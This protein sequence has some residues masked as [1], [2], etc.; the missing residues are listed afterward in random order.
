MKLSAGLDSPH[1]YGCATHNHDKEGGKAKAKVKAHV[2]RSVSAT[3]SQGRHS[4]GIAP[5][6]QS[7]THLILQPLEVSNQSKFR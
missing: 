2:I 7:N 6:L 5:H 1:N 4:C 3:H